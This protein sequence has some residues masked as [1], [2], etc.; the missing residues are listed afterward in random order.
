ML[1]NE[2][3]FTLIELLVVIIILGILVSLAAPRL[4]G[5]TEAARI[6]ATRADIEGGI[7][8]SLDLFEMDMGKYPAALDELVRKPADDPLWRGP[9]LKKGVPKDPWGN[10]YV[11]RF[12]GTLNPETYDL[13][14]LG[15]DKKD[16]TGDEI[17]N[18]IS[19]LK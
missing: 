9:Y 14:S 4:A 13:L 15:P 3:G 10:L 11:Y 17:T 5:R 18:A 2:S 1:K 6:Q 7:A 16:G 12:P 8:T 19:G